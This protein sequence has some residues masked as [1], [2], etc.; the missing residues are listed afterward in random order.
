[1][2]APPSHRADVLRIA[3]ATEY[4]VRTVARALGGASVRP[5]TLRAIEDA[6]KRLRI[7]LPRGAA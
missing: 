1:M 7:E 2:S 3:A 5:S 6:A 4:D